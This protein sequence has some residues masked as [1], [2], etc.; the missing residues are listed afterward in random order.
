M[1]VYGVKSAIISAP[2]AVLPMTAVAL[3]PDCFGIEALAPV[4]MKK[5]CRSGFNARFGIVSSTILFAKAG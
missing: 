2:S 3:A 1:D 5:S 4:L